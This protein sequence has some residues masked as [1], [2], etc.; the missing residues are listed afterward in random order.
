MLRLYVL[1]FPRVEVNHQPVKIDRRKAVALLVYLAMES[2]AHSRES[3]AALLW[4]DYDQ[5]KAFAYLRRELW[6]LNSE[7]GADFFTIDRETV[8][9]SETPWVDALEFR[10]RLEESQL[11]AA[12]DLYQN[13]FLAGFTLRDCPDFDDWQYL[14]AEQLHQAAVAA[15]HQLVET[16]TQTKAGIDYAQRWLALDPLDEAAHRQLM[17]F[18][19]LA[20]QRSLALRQYEDCVRLLREELGTTPQAETTHLYETLQQNRGVIHQLPPQ[21]TAFVGRQKELAE[22]HRLLETPDCRLLTLTGP[23]GIGKTR[24]AIETGR[25][26]S[27]SVYFVPLVA[28]ESLL[29]AIT[30]ALEL[31]FDK[32]LD[33]KPQ[34]FAY[35]N[36]KQLLFIL[37]N[38]E[39][40]LEEAILLNEL[41][42]AA[43]AIRLLV[44]S[45]ERLNIQSEWVLNIEGMEHA[46]AVQLFIQHAR[47]MGAAPTDMESIVKICQLVDG[48]PLGIELAATWTKALTCVEI[49]NEIQRSLDFLTSSLRDT[50]ERHRSLRAVFE[51][52]WNLLA[53]EERRIFC[54]LSIFRGEFQREAA[55]Q[56]IPAT[57]MQLSALV[58][59]SLLRRT[60]SGGYEIH[61]LLRQYAAEKLEGCADEAVKNR[62]AAYFLDFIRVREKLLVGPTQQSILREIS[63][64]LENVRAAWHWAVQQG[65]W[66]KIS[67]AL[68]VLEYFDMRGLAFEGAD[69]FGAAVEKL[70]LA[71]SLTPQMELILARTLAGYAWFG[72]WMGYVSKEDARHLIEKSIALSEKNGN[73][74]ELAFGYLV[75]GH[76]YQFRYDLDKA[77]DLCRRS[78]A[79][80]QEIG[81]QYWVGNALSALAMIADLRGDYALSSSLYLEMLQRYRD[82]GESIGCAGALVSLTN[83]TRLQGHFTEARAYGEE[84]VR[85]FRELAQPDRLSNALAN[86]GLVYKALGDYD[87]AEAIF[88]ES[89][90]ICEPL[91]FDRGMLAAVLNNLGILARLRGHYEEAVRIHQRSVTLFKEVDSLWGLGFSQNDLGTALLAL[92][93]AE[94]AL[95][96]H[97][98]SLRLCRQMNNRYDLADSLQRMGQVYTEKGQ[99]DRAEAC[100]KE[101]LQ[102]AREIRVI[103]LILEILTHLGLLF[104]KKGDDRALLLLSTAYHAAGAE[105]HTRHRIETLNLVLPAPSMEELNH[106]GSSVI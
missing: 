87:A 65:D 34:L 62:F 99:F 73:K 98:D 89:R 95:H 72:A 69:F 63:R 33:Q 15:L 45:R 26:S 19:A 50:P 40:M 76:H 1:G 103:P 58:D 68:G 75:L 51:H 13:R 27:W 38:F 85:L 92:G 59:K 4:G 6:T 93:R 48:M 35:L 60:E 74:K 104:L 81:E 66:A 20:G 78:Y 54:Q 70:R 11:A 83:T 53:D 100:F 24:L 105:H 57:L 31:T 49:A 91:T 102:M 46:G 61:E 8:S 47:K 106:P 10:R 9:L 86:L 29:P 41:L 101:A 17:K 36:D 56:I 23:G 16:E 80:Y 37:D 90:Q 12:V 79:L 25:Q 43:P 96:L 39:H 44:T 42:Q 30:D 2:R 14:K 71:E 3:L 28:A 94:E 5:S 21:A 7:L 32:K 67:D 22:I 18:Y 84:S 97:E 55:A 52:S 88:E 77:E 82:L 64:E